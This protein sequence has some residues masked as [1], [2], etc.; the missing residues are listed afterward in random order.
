VSLIHQSAKDYLL[1]KGYDPNPE[2]EVFRVKIKDANIEITKRCLDYLQQGAYADGEV[3]LMKDTPHLEAF[4]LL[5]YAVLHWFEHARHLAHSDEVFTLPHTFFCE[6]SAVRTSW[7]K[8]Y[9]ST[10]YLHKENI[11]NDPSQLLHIA[12]WFGILPLTEKLLLRQGYWNKVKRF[13]YINKNDTKG[14]TPLHWAAC[15]GY[16]AIVQLLLEKGAV[17]DAKSGS[18]DTALLE[19]ATYGRQAI[20]QLLLEKGAN[21]NAC[22]RMGWSAL[23]YPVC[24]EDQTLLLYLLENGA[25]TDTTNES[26]MIPLVL[27]VFK[28]SLAIVRL[29]LQ[30]GANIE[31]ANTG[32][33]WKGT[34]LSTAAY[35]GNEGMVRLL[36]KEG[37]NIKAKDSNGETALHCAAECGYKAIVQLLLENGANIDQMDEYGYTPRDLAA[38]F[39]QE[40][41]ARLLATHI[42]DC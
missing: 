16:L 35:F 14:R 15:R 13:I 7:L 5:S 6:K 8:S 42:P 29:L 3:N 28:G 33:C 27:A 26:H 37:A 25:K 12:S 31:A 41:V 9:N 38:V 21:I 32:S 34:A 22:G 10:L 40:S 4:P 11:L 36:L 20:V 19:A 17:V 1:R 24:N 23:C 30:H 18:G 39:R 2:L